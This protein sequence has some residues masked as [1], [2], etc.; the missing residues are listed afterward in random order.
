MQVLPE[1]WDSSLP[2][3]AGDYLVEMGRMIDAC[4]IEKRPYLD[5]DCNIYTLSGMLGI[6]VHHLSYYFSEQK[7]K[8]FNDF[9]NEWRIH[10]AKDLIL[11][12]K[13][14]E[15]S[16][17]AIGFSSGF[18][19]RITFFRAFKKA[20]GISPETFMSRNGNQKATG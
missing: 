1:T 12:G 2:P 5:P 16:P 14:R 7:K 13:A 18:S 15:M 10:H 6:P 3:G 8:S 17:E 11:T 20:E 9:R 4:M 19:S